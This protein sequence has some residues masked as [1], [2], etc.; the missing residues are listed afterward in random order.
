MRVEGLSEGFRELLSFPDLLS[1]E[2]FSA[3]GL[4]P[5]TSVTLTVFLRPDGLKQNWCQIE[6]ARGDL[7]AHSAKRAHWCCLAVVKGIG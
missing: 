7:G 5:V 3:A 2:E 1:P 4:S 6:E